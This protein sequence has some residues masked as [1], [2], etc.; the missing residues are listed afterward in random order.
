MASRWL[1]EDPELKALRRSMLVSGVSTY[2]RA[3]GVVEAMVSHASPERVFFF[4]AEAGPLVASFREAGH[5]F[6]GVRPPMEPGGEAPWLWCRIDGSTVVVPHRAVVDNLA[7]DGLGDGW[8]VQESLRRAVRVAKSEHAIV[9]YVGRGSSSCTAFG[10]ALF[11]AK[12]A[13]GVQ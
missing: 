13:L 10:D 12:H 9:L 1:A 3:P 4:K 8:Y 11:Y 2:V 5:V 6:K 7:T